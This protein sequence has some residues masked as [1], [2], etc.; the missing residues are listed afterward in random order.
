MITIRSFI[1]YHPCYNHDAHFIYGRIHLPVAAKCNIQCNYCDR[2]EGVSYHSYRPGVTKRI[3]SPTEAA[4]LVDKKLKENDIRVVGIAGPGEPLFNEETFSTLDI[5]KKKHTD[6]IFCLSTNGLLL[7][8]K[9]KD[10]VNVGIKT[11]SV[12]INTVDPKIAEEIYS[13]ITYRGIIFEG[14]KATKMLIEKQ[15]SGLSK[16]VKNGMVVKVNSI[17]IPELN[18]DHLEEVSEK[19]KARGAFIHN[20]VP[21]IPLAKF[22]SYRRPTCKELSDTRNRCEKIIKQFRLCK[23]CR[24]D[25]V[26][27]PFN[28]N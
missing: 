10:M 27:I 20:I 12:T 18:M 21:L 19:I 25:S 28:E 11:V 9:I 5:I 16:A 23:Q 6:L 17:L 14:D 8:D 7:E 15:L 13:H 24:A 22:K 4:C 26:G 3:L 1:K 2:R